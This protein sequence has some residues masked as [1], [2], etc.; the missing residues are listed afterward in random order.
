LAYSTEQATQL[1]QASRPRSRRRDL[2]PV[3][4]EP[5]RELERFEMNGKT[6]VEV[7]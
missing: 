5:P 3:P 1:A 2:R 6:Y 7:P 4:P